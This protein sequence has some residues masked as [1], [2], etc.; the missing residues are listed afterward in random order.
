M[1]T[2]LLLSCLPS[3]ALVQAEDAPVPKVVF[4]RPGQ[5]MVVPSGPAAVVIEFDVGMDAR[6]FSWGPGTDTMP[7]PTEEPRWMNDNIWAFNLDLEPN[8]TYSFVLN[9]EPEQG[10]VSLKGVPLETTVVRFSTNDLRSDN[11]PIARHQAAADALITAMQERYAYRDQRA[12]DWVQWEKETQAKLYPV[13]NSKDFAKLATEQL[14][15]L[16]DLSIQVQLKGDSTPTYRPRVDPNYDRRRTMGLLTDIQSLSAYVMQAQATPEIAY[17]AIDFWTRTEALSAEE[18]F[19]T[20]LKSMESDKG[21]IIDV[22][23]NRGGDQAIALNLAG[24]LLS[25]PGVYAQTASPN[26]DGVLGEAVD[27]SAEPV[28]PRFTKP[29]A[30][31]QGPTNMGVNEVFVLAA[32]QSERVRT[33]GGSTYGAV[34]QTESIDLGNDIR[35]LLPTER[36][37]RPSGEVYEGQGLPPDQAVPWAEEGDPVLAAAIAWLNTQ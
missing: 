21:L 18:L 26:A 30:I 15:L 1:I 19:T 36:T 14:A 17:L 29:V 4:T 3:T 11:A 8:T 24:R 31:L 12:V 34:G 20:A 33:F 7:N 10:F 9:P 28:R 16:E 35:I 27:Q 5:D 32:S 23:S 25:E 37:T 2:A 6:S 22:R 13:R